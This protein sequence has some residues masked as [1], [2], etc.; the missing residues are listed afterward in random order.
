[1]VLNAK[2]GPW[3]SICSTGIT[4]K[5]GRNIDKV[6]IIDNKKNTVNTETLLFIYKEYMLE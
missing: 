3:I 4:G 6:P 2:I 1:M 5:L